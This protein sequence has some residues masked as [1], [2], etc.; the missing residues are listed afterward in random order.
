MKL[1]LR[2]KGHGSAPPVTRYF[3]KVTFSIQAPEWGTP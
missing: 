2:W 1:Q 3:S